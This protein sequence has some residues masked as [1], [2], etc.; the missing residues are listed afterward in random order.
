MQSNIFAGRV[1]AD[2]ETNGQENSVTRLTL[3][4]NE[5]TGEGKDER[6]VSI[7]FTAFGKRG[8][9]IAN[10]VRKGDQLIVTYRIENNRWQKDG[11]DQYGYNFII[12]D[13]EFGAAGAATREALAG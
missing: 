11:V 7:P 8:E 5:Y 6:T 1:A 4:T 10:N 3:M 2:P 12:Q 9:V 13:F